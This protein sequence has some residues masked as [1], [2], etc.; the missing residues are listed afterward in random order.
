MFAVTD[1]GYP[2]EA[3]T[4]EQ[5]VIAYTRNSAYAQF[6]EQEKGT[7]TAGKFADLG[8]LSQDIFIIP[9]QQLPVTKSVLTMVGGKIVFQAQ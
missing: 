9:V 6:G 4:R 3:M 2:D 1:P 8:V 7:L 5:A